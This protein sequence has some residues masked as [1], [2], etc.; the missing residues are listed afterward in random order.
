MRGLENATA[1]AWVARGE[2]SRPLYGLSDA[3][4]QVTLDLK[5]GAK[6]TV[7]FGREASANSV[8]ASVTFEGAVWILEFP[9]PLF[10]DLLAYVPI[11]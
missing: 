6:Q 5:T 9:W 10:R 1:L 2:Q 11:P 4:L 3:S 7:Q 8:Y